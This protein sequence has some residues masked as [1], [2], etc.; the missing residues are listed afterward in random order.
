MGLNR[1]TN[2]CQTVL[3]ALLLLAGWVSD[4]PAAERAWRL[5][6]PAAELLNQE[7]L[8]AAFSQQVAADVE[9]QLAAKAPPASEHT[10]LA[11]LVHQRLLAGDDAAALD[12]ADR[13][14][15]RLPEGPA[16]AFA[17]LTTRAFVAARRAS[18]A[19]PGDARFN[20]V[21]AREFTVLLETLP[22]TEGMNALLVAQRE[23]YAAMSLHASEAEVAR[24]LSVLGDRREC[25]LPEAD[26]LI[27]WK[28]Q[29][30][31]MLPVREELVAA[32]DRT[33]ADRASRRSR[34]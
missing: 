32:L 14:R 28:H 13:I 17:G 19:Q 22:A 25:T 33:L 4:V 20:R 29:L 3:T 2:P 1:G 24:V 15:A 11:L 16:R 8:F 12:C 21:F 5:P 6:A 10:L 31:N 7:Q 26:A 9:Q 27:R 30:A 34:D 23:K 18:R